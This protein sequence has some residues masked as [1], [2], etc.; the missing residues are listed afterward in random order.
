MATGAGLLYFPAILPG[1]TFIGVERREAIMEVTKQ[2]GLRLELKYCE[3]CGGLLLRPAGSGAVYCDTC[4]RDMAEV[5]VRG[6][7]REGKKSR[8]PRLP[9]AIGDEPHGYAGRAAKHAGGAL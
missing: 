4:G 6:R 2:E 8:Q 9:V 3:R 5:A 1:S 7:R